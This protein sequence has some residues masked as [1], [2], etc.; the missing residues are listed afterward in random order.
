MFLILKN[1]CTCESRRAAAPHLRRAR[2]CLQ[3]G[4]QSNHLFGIFIELYLH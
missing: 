1:D 3:G 4:G 2:A